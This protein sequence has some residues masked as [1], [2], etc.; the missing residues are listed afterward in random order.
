MVD[1]PAGSSTPMKQPV[2]LVA[3]V[4]RSMGVSGSKPDWYPGEPMPP[5]SCSEGQGQCAA[6]G[7]GE[8]YSEGRAA[9]SL[10]AGASTASGIT[11]TCSRAR[12]TTMTSGGGGGENMGGGGLNKTEGGREIT[13]LPVV[14]LTD[15]QVRGA[16]QKL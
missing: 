9:A 3:T 12:D 10:T 8:K 5:C 14:A 4:N 11:S 2:P 6:A 15:S 7:G 16:K 1:V 13:S